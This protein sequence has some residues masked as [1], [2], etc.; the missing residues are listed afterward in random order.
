MSSDDKIIYVPRIQDYF[1]IMYFQ[2]GRE[3]PKKKEL[4]YTDSIK[5][6]FKA[7]DLYTT[8]KLP[9][10]KIPSTTINPT[11][12]ITFSNFVASGLQNQWKNLLLTE[13]DEQL[14]YVVQYCQ[15]ENDN[16][17]TLACDFL[18]NKNNIVVE[19]IKMIKLILDGRIDLIEELRK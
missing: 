15:S 3:E 9:S 6:R 19:D 18:R 16:L 4:Y 1:N 5:D 10:F 17:K 2:I 12:I 8:E 14:R 11:R 13:G 7:V